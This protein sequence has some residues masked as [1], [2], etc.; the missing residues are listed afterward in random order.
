M[1]LTSNLAV[2]KL[3]L[4]VFVWKLVLVCLEHD[5]LS[6]A[7]HIPGVKNKL[8]DCLSRFQIQTFKQLQQASIDTFYMHLCCNLRNIS[9]EIPYIHKYFHLASF[10][11]EH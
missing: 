7:K 10:L 8:A 5:I 11:C 1:L 3:N 2:I 9:S 6:K 4:M